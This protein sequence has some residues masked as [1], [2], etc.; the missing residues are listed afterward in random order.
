MG[1]GS[2]SPSKLEQ[3]L[4]YTEPVEAGERYYG[5]EN[6]GNTCYCN[7]VMQ[8]LYFCSPLR[9]EL[10]ARHTQN[11]SSTAMATGSSQY[12][13]GSLLYQLAELFAVITN[14]KKLSGRVAPQAFMQTLR[15][16]NELFRGNMQQD[17][18]EFYN[19]II[20]DMAD[21]L[22]RMSADKS[23]DQAARKTTWIHDLFQ[24]VLTNE[25]KC[26]C[27]E[28]VTHRDEPFVDLPL[29]IEQ[30]CSVTACLRNFSRTETLTGR[31]KFF[32][33]TCCALQE[34]EKRMC[35]RRLPRVLTLHL[36]RFKYMEQIQNFSK[37]SHRVVFPLELRMPNMA[38]DSAADADGILYHLFAVVV[39]IG[40]G[41]NHGHYVA[42]VKSQ[43]RWM[44]F[45]DDLV[46]VVDEAV[47]HKVFGLSNH[48]G[49]S[50]NTG[51]LLFYDCGERS[52]ASAP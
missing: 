8:A 31:N 39:H 2:S 51:Y 3:D 20:N 27:C 30:N 47:L 48:L 50:T 6:F 36:K 9:K 44:L 32:C 43:G 1:T 34:A 11:S 49:G 19:F 40:R 28:T 38:R 26:I 35:L 42:V 52:A 29:D 24:G 22:L 10:L 13:A 21:T 14:T 18:H 16:T 17:A 12:P 37:L 41:L 33:E 25:T 15:E 45:D 23:G 46:E 7:S 5:L 4:G